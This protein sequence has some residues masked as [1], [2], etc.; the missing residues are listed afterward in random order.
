VPL[1]DVIGP[2]CRALV[3]RK[4]RGLCLVLA[5]PSTV[6]SGAYSKTL[7]GL[8]RRLIVREVACPLLV[9]LVEEGLVR[10]SL[11]RQV[12]SMYLRGSGKP[13]A[14]VLGCTHYPLLKAEMRSLVGPRVL[15]LDSA[16]ETARGVQDLFGD[17][18]K[19]GK[20]SCFVSDDPRGFRLA[21][22]RLLGLRPDKVL[23]VDIERYPEKLS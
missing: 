11:T 6:R 14:L 4:P 19:G 21:A 8:D 23:K 16:T 20:L 3:E 18:G 15:I 7:R 9:P 2:A 13:S 22:Q 12:L 17:G 10:G 5:T 1:V